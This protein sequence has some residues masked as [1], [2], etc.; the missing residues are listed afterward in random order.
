MVIFL[1]AASFAKYYTETIDLK[2]EFGITVNHSKCIS[3][4]INNMRDKKIDYMGLYSLRIFIILC[5]SCMRLYAGSVLTFLLR[6]RH[7]ST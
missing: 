5:V 3:K 2:N 7:Y 1:N 6:M 4:Y